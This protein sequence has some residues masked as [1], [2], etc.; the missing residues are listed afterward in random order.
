[1]FILFLFFFC[2]NIYSATACFSLFS[3]TVHKCGGCF[4]IPVSSAFLL[5]PPNAVEEK[6]T[7]RCSRVRYYKGCEVK[8][9]D[10]EAF[11]SR[12]LKI[13]PTGIVFNPPVTVLLSHSA[14][15]DQDLL[16]YYDLFVEKLRPTVCEELKTETIGSDQGTDVFII[17]SCILKQKYLGNTRSSRCIRSDSSGGFSRLNPG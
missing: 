14:Y 13:E 2:F 7:L 16:D 3:I 4:S 1:M 8:P 11:V 10:G 5:F 12:I 6:V 9:K 17:L 15:E